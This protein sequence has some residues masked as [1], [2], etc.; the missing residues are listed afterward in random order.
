MK[1]HVAVR[2]FGPNLSRIEIFLVFILV[3]GSYAA[4]AQ[5]S[6]LMGQ[7]RGTYQGITIT[8]VMKPNGQYTQTTQKGTLMTMQWGAYKLVSPNTIIFP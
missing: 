1:Q 7:W 8:I 4:P 6:T 2:A 5:Q 3:L